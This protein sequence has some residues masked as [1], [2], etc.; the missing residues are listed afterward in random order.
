M[1]VINVY[2]HL[3]RERMYVKMIYRLIFVIYISI[4]VYSDL[5]M[6]VKNTE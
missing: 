3:P 6:H 2:L 5:Q 4:C 1:Y